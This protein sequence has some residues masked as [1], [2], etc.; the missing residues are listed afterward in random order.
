MVCC[1]FPWLLVRNQLTLPAD[2][3]SAKFSRNQ[4]QFEE[5]IAN[6]NF[7]FSSEAVEKLKSELSQTNKIIQTQKQLK[8]AEA[9]LTSLKSEFKNLGDENNPFR[10]DL[11]SLSED[12][13]FKRHYLKDYSEKE[14]T[15]KNGLII[16]PVKEWFVERYRDWGLLGAEVMVLYDDFFKTNKPSKESFEQLVEKAIENI[17]SQGHFLWFNMR[18]P[19]HNGWFLTSYAEDA[20]SFRKGIKEEYSNRLKRQALHILFNTFFYGSDMDLI[21][22]PLDYI[23]FDFSLRDGASPLDRYYQIFF[24]L[25]NETHLIDLFKTEARRRPIEY[26]RKKVEDLKSKEPWRMR[27]ILAEREAHFQE[28]FP[29]SWSYGIFKS[30]LELVSFFEEREEEGISPISQ[31]SEKRYKALREVFQICYSRF[32]FRDYLFYQAFPFSK[33]DFSLSIKESQSL[34]HPDSYCRI[35]GTIFRQ[36]YLENKLELYKKY[37][38]KSGD[39]YEIGV[40][41]REVIKILSDQEERSSGSY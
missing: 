2:S 3:V 35:I 28:Q 16:P 41:L 36:I 7:R 19:I 12:S 15:N 23:K 9:R 6:L 5:E 27:L 40:K 4:S 39:F 20:K 33:F 25:L 38:S 21:K 10:V 22:K 30:L 37:V 11:S 14:R 17:L 32:A 18:Y 1:G 31:V 34:D 29:Q 8:E 24:P 26:A 13:S